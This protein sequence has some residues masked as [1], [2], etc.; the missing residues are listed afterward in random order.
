M[1]SN[2]HSNKSLEN[3]LTDTRVELL[4]WRRLDICPDTIVRIGQNLR[5]LHLQ[6]S[7]N[8]AV[9]RSWSEAGGLP[10]LARH[11]NLKRIMVIFPEERPDMGHHTSKDLENLKKRLLRNWPASSQ[12]RPHPP[13]NKTRAGTSSLSTD[14]ETGS[15]GLEFPKVDFWKAKFTTSTLNDT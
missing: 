11:G 9:L 14:T 6:W 13:D 2:Y 12:K 5:E 10:K 3:A 1:K 8:N 7:G 4:D 15:Q